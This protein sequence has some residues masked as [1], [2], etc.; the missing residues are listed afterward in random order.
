MKKIYGIIASLVFLCSVC[1]AQENT[2]KFN[3]LG[4]GETFHLSLFTDGIIL[5]GGTALVGT[6]LFC[7]KVLKINRIDVPSLPR[8]KD[9]VPAIDQPFMNPYSKPLDLTATGIECALFATPLLFIPQGSSEW[10]TIGTMYVETLMWAYGLK[11]M[12][13]ICVNRA[14]PYMY[15]NDPPQ[16]Y[17]DNYDWANSFPSGHS[18]FSFA[19]ASFTSYVFSKYYPDSKWKWVVTGGCYSLAASVGCLRML[20]GNHFFTDVCTG[21]LIGTACGILIPWLHTIGP[22]NPSD[23]VQISATPAN[24]NVLI[25]F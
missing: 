20:S 13:K 11:E 12:G 15:F 25:K 19:A 10:F 4:N 14:R 21:A 2:K 16:K 5:G 9:S 17:I 8:N 3:L 1:T 23:N 7:K 6:D 22:K 24:L 18:A